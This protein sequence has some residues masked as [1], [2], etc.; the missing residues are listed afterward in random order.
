MKYLLLL[1]L[2]SCAAT[3]S[4]SGNYLVTAKQNHTVTLKG[5]NHKI[6]IPAENDTVKVGD[7]IPVVVVVS[8]KTQHM[9]R[10]H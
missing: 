3:K 8:P 1:L 9:K 2:I 6:N 10:S 7:I 4:Q 5:F